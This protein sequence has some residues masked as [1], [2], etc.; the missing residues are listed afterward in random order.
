MKTAVLSDIHGN[1]LAL[2]AVLDAAEAEGI[3]QFVNLGDIASG[4]LWPAETVDW[5]MRLDWPT[6]RGNHERQLLSLP[7]ERMGLSDAQTWPR[8]NPAQRQWL[9]GLPTE[10]RLPHGLRAVHGAPGDDLQYLLETVTPTFGVDGGLGIRAATAA[11]IDQRLDDE[12][13]ELLL[14]GH[15]HVPRVLRHGWRLIV[16]PG[17]VGLQAYDDGH[18]HK[19]FVANGSPHARWAVVE[20]TA[21]GWQAELRQTAYDWQAAAEQALAQG[22]GDWADSL[23]TG[24]VGR[25][26]ADQA[27]HR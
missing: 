3:R 26:E 10:L 1:V 15:S 9:A 11:E 23:A 16:N 21:A 14:C 19:H 2:Q 24:H 6:L 5:L 8:L 7:P 27:R 4:P 22:R 18:P 20:R 25:T 13:C 12:P 17:S